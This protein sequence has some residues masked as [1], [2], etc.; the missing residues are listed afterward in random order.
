MSKIEILEE[1]PRLDAVARREILERICDME[2]GIVTPEERA[3]IDERLA[4]CRRS[5][6]GW[7]EWDEA[8]KRV[9]SRLPVA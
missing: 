3:F 2:D 4:Q 5:P 7:S 1:L 6:A 9:L 8:R